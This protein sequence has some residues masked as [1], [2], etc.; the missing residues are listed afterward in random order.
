M[1]AVLEIKNRGKNTPLPR[2]E[3]YTPTQIRVKKK[4]VTTFFV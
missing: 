1:E 2:L 4:S 3:K